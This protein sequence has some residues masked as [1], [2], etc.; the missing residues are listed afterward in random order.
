[1]IRRKRIIKRESYHRKNCFFCEKRLLPDYKDLENLKKFL[2]ERGKI[3]NR[4][5]SGVCA[6][7]QRKLALAIK[8]SRYL[9]LLP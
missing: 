5:R 6:K 7:H 4:N 9:A 1:M 3:I 8:R 2:S